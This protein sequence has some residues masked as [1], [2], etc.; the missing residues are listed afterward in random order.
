MLISFKVSNFKSILE[1]VCLNMLADQD[2]QA[3]VQ[4][5]YELEGVGKKVNPFSVIM[6]ANGSGKSSVLDAL[7]FTR[8]F[9]LRRGVT[10]IPQN[11]LAPP[12]MPS[13]FEVCFYMSSSMIGKPIQKYVL[14]VS[15]F[16]LASEKI[17]YLKNNEWNELWNHDFS[18]GSEP[19]D[20]KENLNIA[21]E[22]EDLSELESYSNTYD[23]V[24]FFK[25]LVFFNSID[26]NL[27]QYFSEDMSEYTLKN[28]AMLDPE[29]RPLIRTDSNASQPFFKDALL[30]LLN[31]LGV[32]A[33]D[34][35]FKNLGTDLYCED[36][37]TTH[38]F[39]DPNAFPSAE[40]LDKSEHELEEDI[41]II[42]VP[43]KDSIEEVTFAKI[44]T[45]ALTGL[46]YR[47][48][49]MPI[50]E[51]SAGTIRLVKLAFTMLNGL[52]HSED[53]V[54]FIDEMDAGLHDALSAEVVRQFF[55][56]SRKIEVHGEFGVKERSQL[57][58]TS[59]NTVLLKDGTIRKDQ[60]WFAEMKEENRTTDLYSLADLKGI[61][62]TE[63]FAENYL[64]GAYGAIPKRASFDEESEDE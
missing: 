45:Y 4:N 64:R 21:W 42:D 49:G 24:Q 31:A 9:Y 56:C 25:N 34:L 28:I 32:D 62:S 27:D 20:D 22:K 41:G 59:H 12:E 46:I 60:I 11:R 33:V 37:G 38:E 13:R 43:D 57:I 58:V 3:L 44:R 18:L 7:K 10:Y 17:Y 36:A 23:T 2:D 14:E 52:F 61:K 54:L 53:I 16:G 8:E 5:L 6:G 48:Y 15:S 50:T 51:E 63:D 29:I 19:L 40:E 55:N 35:V 39:I 30:K 1:P 26:N 47:S